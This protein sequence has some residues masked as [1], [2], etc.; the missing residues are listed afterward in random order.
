M[1]LGDFG[2][3]VDQTVLFSVEA[4]GTVTSQFITTGYAEVVAESSPTL[5]W[6]NG[7]E[8]GIYSVDGAEATKLT[9]AAVNN[10]PPPSVLGKSGGNIFLAYR[11]GEF[12]SI[13]MV[14]SS[15]GSVALTAVAEGL[16]GPPL[17]VFK[18]AGGDFWFGIE[19]ADGRAFA[20]VFQGEYS[21]WSVGQSSI[22]PYTYGDPSTGDVEIW[23][24]RQRASAGDD[25]R[26]C[27]LPPSKDCWTMPTSLFVPWAEVDSGGTV[28]AVYF[29]GDPKEAFLWRNLEPAQ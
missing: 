14:T 13:G 2:L 17:E 19:R 3:M 29:D 21:E 25:W 23:G 18:R 28:H 16:S 7:A 22:V 15:G 24:V 12:W 1:L 27:E 4:D 11:A 8:A 9:G 26:W 20:S 6:L 10:N 5:M